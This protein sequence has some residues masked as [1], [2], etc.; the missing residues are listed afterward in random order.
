[1][2]V[3]NPLDQKMT[4]SHMTVFSGATHIMDAD[5]EEE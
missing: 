2:S 3:S 1:M 5:L 4:S